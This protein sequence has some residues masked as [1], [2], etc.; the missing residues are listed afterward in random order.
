VPDKNVVLTGRGREGEPE[1]LKIT[2]RRV[3]RL[4]VKLKETGDWAVIHG[5]RGWRSHRRLSK[6]TREKA[7]RILWQEV[8]RGFGPIKGARMPRFQARVLACPWFIGTKDDQ[9]H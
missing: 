1:E 9:R 5:L 3:G 8:Y 2:E 6:G 4:L 7:T